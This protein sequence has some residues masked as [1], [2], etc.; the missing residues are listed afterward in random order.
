M[1][2]LLSS[3]AVDAAVFQQAGVRLSV[4]RAFSRDRDFDRGIATAIGKRSTI[5]QSQR[6][7]FADARIRIYERVRW[8]VYALQTSQRP[9]CF[10]NVV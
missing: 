2:L 1:P 5:G 8:V 7:C 4:W 6:L 9:Q 10:R 3:L